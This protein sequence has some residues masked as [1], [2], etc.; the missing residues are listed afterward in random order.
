MAATEQFTAFYQAN[1]EAAQRCTAAAIEGAQRLM[2]VQMEATREVME[3]NNSRWREAMTRFDPSRG[4]LDWPSLMTEQMQIAMEMTRASMEGA[5]RVYNEYVRTMQEQ[6]RVM[7]DAIEQT[8]GQGEALTTQAVRDNERAAEEVGRRAAEVVSQMSGQVAGSTAA[9][10]SAA[11]GTA[12][13]AAQAEEAQ[14]RRTAK[15]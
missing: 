13:S 14:R 15:A 7:S 9:A 11:S 1:G 2:R 4:P 5:A 6:S 3:R 12:Q 8:R 10:Q